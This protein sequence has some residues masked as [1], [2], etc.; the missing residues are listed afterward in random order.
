MDIH[1][2]SLT[3][4]V[5]CLPWAG[6]SQSRPDSVTL[7]PQAI[8]LQ[9]GTAGVG[10]FYKRVLSASPGV[11]LRAGG[12][13]MAYR[14]PV[15]IQT[16]PGS[17]L[18]V[19]PDFM[20]G[21]V[22]ADLAW[23]PFPRRAFFVAAG[24]GYTWHPN[25]SFVINAESA[26]S[27]GGL[28]LTADDVGTIHLDLRWQPVL[29]YVGWGFERLVSRR[30]VGI[31]FEMGMLYLGRPQLR[32]QYEGFLETTNLDEQVP[33]VERNLA[34]YR[35]LPSLNVTLSYALGHRP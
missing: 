19:T 11:S 13:Y 9:V 23:H 32:L 15:R 30:R 3:W 4:L 1:R 21:L 5:L 22:R 27:L 31:G 14:K 29:G 7:P 35:Y 8:R 33:V 34:G 28:E 10:L 24:M 17:F 18:N 26:L 25:L 2:Y 16:D 12:Q 20:I 6:I